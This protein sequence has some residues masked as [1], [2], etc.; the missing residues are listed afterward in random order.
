MVT[1]HGF[2]CNSESF[3]TKGF[4]NLVCPELT[5]NSLNL[6]LFCHFLKN[7][8]SPCSLNQGSSSWV[9]QVF[10]WVNR[11]HSQIPCAFSYCQITIAHSCGKGPRNCCHC[12]V[13]APR[14]LCPTQPAFHYLPARAFSPAHFL[15]STICTNSHIVLTDLRPHGLPSQTTA[16]GH[17]YT[18]RTLS[19]YPPSL[20]PHL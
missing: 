4:V 13:C 14:A 3:L 10:S 15:C 7:L 1:I 18:Q 19:Q 12:Y 20:L 6:S 9:S 17:W 11:S 8:S 2:L 5:R 16:S